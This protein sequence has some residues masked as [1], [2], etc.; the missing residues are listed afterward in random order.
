MFE[1]GTSVT[2]KYIYHDGKIVYISG[3]VL[4]SN[5]EFSVVSDFSETTKRKV[6]NK[7]L[8]VIS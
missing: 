6:P 1:I 5:N 3:F 7:N 2:A 4:E 8:T